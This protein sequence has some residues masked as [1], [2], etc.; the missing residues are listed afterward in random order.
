[1]KPCPWGIDVGRCWP[2]DAEDLAA[3][4]PRRECSA[5][6]REV[7]AARAWVRRARQC[8]RR[9]R[10][11]RWFSPTVPSCRRPIRRPGVRSSAHG[12]D[13]MS[14]P[15]ATPARSTA[16][17]SRRLQPLSASSRARPA[18]TTATS[19]RP[20]LG[21][22]TAQMG[23]MMLATRGTPAGIGSGQISGLAERLARRAPAAARTPATSKR[24]TRDQARRAGR[25]LLQPGRYVTRLIPQSYFNRQTRYFP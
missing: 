21:M 25:P 18:A 10:R 8:R 3:G 14:N 20:R 23:M 16:A 17:C 5:I 11:C 6:R 9:R 2:G 15:F 19:A 13:L 22:S 1:M 24:R 4:T 7:R 12:R